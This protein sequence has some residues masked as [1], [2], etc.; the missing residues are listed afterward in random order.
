MNKIS[1]YIIIITFLICHASYGQKPLSI[2]GSK[3][4][5]TQFG[6]L[7]PDSVEYRLYRF[8]LGNEAN[9]VQIFIGKIPTSYLELKSRILTINA[10]N[11]IYTLPDD[12]TISTLYNDIIKY[13]T[14][15]SIAFFNGIPQYIE[16][17]GL[18]YFDMNVSEGVKYEYIIRK[19][20]KQGRLLE[21]NFT[22]PNPIP[23]KKPTF[24]VKFHSQII[25]D[26]AITLKFSM[27][28]DRFPFDFKVLRQVYLQ[29]KF[30]KIEPIKSFY[31][32]NDTM[33]IQFTDHE[34]VPGLIYQYTIIPYD[35]LG[36]F[37]LYPDTIRI[38]FSGVFSKTPM[39][40]K[41]IANSKEKQNAIELKW[42]F[43]DNKPINSIAIF[44]SE[45]FDDG[46]TLLT[47]VPGKDTLFFDHNVMPIK[48]YY[49]YIIAN[50]LFGDTPPSSKVIGMMKGNK[51]AN[52]APKDLKIAQTP[53][54]NLLT[55]KKTEIDTRGYYVYRGLGYQAEL[56][57]ITPLIT[58]NEVT[59]SFLDSIQ[60]VPKGVPFSYAVCAENTSYSIGPKSDV[61]FSDPLTPELPTPTN[62]FINRQGNNAFLVWDAITNRSSFINGFL[63]FR[64]EPNANKNKDSKTIKLTEQALPYDQN[65][66]L[67]TTLERGIE[68][69]Y[70]V[71][72]I[73]VGN[74]FSAMSQSFEFMLPE[75]LPFPPT[76]VR[77]T[78]TE[79]GGI[80]YWDTP[81]TDDIKAFRIYREKLDSKIVKIAELN[82][83]VNEYEIINDSKGTY[84]YTI[85][86]V[87]NNDVE[88]NQSDEVWL[89]VE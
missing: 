39:M 37:E 6:T 8:E 47:R 17:M 82:P 28:N 32:Q 66:Y 15:D 29:T 58:N 69:S 14:S 61:V 48:S 25:S 45:N 71:Q 26:D 86:V 88:S 5:F 42:K 49:Y 81:G 9:A 80:L 73:G 62:L 83:A 36:N 53:E 68:Y 4:I 40:H 16:A 10:K 35:V 50:G 77:L 43:D 55:W 24:N 87:N 13:S 70:S 76:G 7:L 31:S 56:K 18:G 19:E 89:L 38:Q 33:F 74:S 75:L 65:T 22:R 20:D 34:L 54:G 51:T 11:P 79:N 2:P 57:Q 30:L 63:I 85:S 60:N 21:E 72:A 59:I 64:S 46:Y 3:G 1:L 27:T 78:K 41:F 44:R 23:G 67:D 52:R 12:S 84:F